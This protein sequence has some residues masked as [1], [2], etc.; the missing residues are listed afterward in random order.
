VS[1]LTPPPKPATGRSS[2][3]QA[4][5]AV[6]VVLVILVG[7]GLYEHH[8]HSSSDSLAN[9]LQQLPHT[10]TTDADGGTTE[11]FQLGPPGKAGD[12]LGDDMFS[13]GRAEYDYEYQYGQYTSS[14]ADLEQAGYQ[15]LASTPV[16][17]WLGTTTAGQKGYC[18]VGSAGDLSQ[19]LVNGQT[20]TGVSV[21]DGATSEVAGE[22]ACEDS[23][24]TNFARII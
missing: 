16:E 20:S 19:W 12:D 23:T 7:L 18:I 11:T 4:Y 1:Q 21:V 9:H 5:A 22:Q 24:I 2:R 10:T 8:R 14:L 3:T 6:T 15:Q 17:I 13:L